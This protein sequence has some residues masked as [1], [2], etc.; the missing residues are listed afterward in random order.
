M[1]TRK[2][3]HYKITAVNY[4]LVED[5]IQ[6]EFCKNFKCYSISLMLWVKRYKKDENVDS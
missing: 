5:K 6:E 3:N 2:S 1:I 4:Y